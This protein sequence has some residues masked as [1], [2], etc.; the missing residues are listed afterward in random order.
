[1]HTR[2]RRFPLVSLITLTL[3]VVAA[4]GALFAQD[5]VAPDVENA[6]VQFSGAINAN[7][8]YVRSGPGENYYP[9]LK[10]DK[11][12]AVTVVGIKFDWLKI[13]PPEGS[14]CY[15][16]KAYVE[17]R[18]DGSVGRVSKPDL[19]VRAGSTLNQLKTT[20]QTKLDEG[21]DVE[22]LGEQDEYFKIKPPAGAYVFVHKQF[23][24]PVKALAAAP[25]TP[26]AGTQQ[27]NTAEQ[28]ADATAQVE[29]S[30]DAQQQQQPTESSDNTTVA[31]VPTTQQSGDQ[32]AE[33]PSTQPVLSAADQ[34]DKLEAEFNAASNQPIQE[35]PVAALTASYQ[36]LMNG[37]EL[38]VSMRRIAELRLATLKI[39][40]EALDQYTSTKKAAEEMKQRQMTLK[41]EQDELQQRIK[42]HDVQIYTAVG[43]VQTSSLQQGNGVLYRLTDP[44]NGRTV[45]YIRTT[46]PEYAKHIGQFVGVRGDL[47]TDTQ[48]SLKVIDSP[49]T[50]ESVDQTQVHAKV[51]A[52]IIPPSLTPSDT[53]STGQD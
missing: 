16:A 9:T 51:T 37:D 5:A 30:Q 24:T 52:Q 43:T 10:L 15:V 17:R 23:V 12:Q 6:K 50:T 53:A 40:Q 26:E 3:I 47:T 1:M 42:E 13:A 22:I 19:N 46:D 38:P 20:V 44:A 21:Q 4:P 31:A 48:L 7:A 25:A 32:T 28:P 27:A 29:Q 34:F 2:S 39:R 36:A 49:K 8:V 45:V 14:F 18:G 11:D 33:A 41:A 35:Q